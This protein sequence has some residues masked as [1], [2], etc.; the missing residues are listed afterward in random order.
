MFGTAGRSESTTYLTTRDIA[1]IHVAPQR[2]P[3]S[4]LMTILVHALYE[5]MQGFS[6]LDVYPRGLFKHKICDARDGQSPRHKA[7]HPRTRNVC[8]CA[9][10]LRKRVSLRKRAASAATVMIGDPAS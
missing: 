8:P 1:M 7:A 3:D 5:V 9:S 6:A 10:K 4:V 2:D